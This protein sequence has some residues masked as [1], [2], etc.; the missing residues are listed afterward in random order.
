MCAC[1][2]TLPTALPQCIC[3]FHKNSLDQRKKLRVPL[4]RRYIV[5]SNI[6]GNFEKP[7]DEIYT[8]DSRACTEIYQK[9]INKKLE[10]II[11]SLLSIKYSKYQENRTYLLQR[12]LFSNMCATGAGTNPFN[13]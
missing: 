12:Q 3:V 2:S 6:A 9:Y 7:G 13:K 5:V 11:Q 4:H 8:C 1:S 10:K